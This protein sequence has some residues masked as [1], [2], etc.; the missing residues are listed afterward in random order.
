MVNVIAQAASIPAYDSANAAYAAGKYEKA[1]KLYESI[2]NDGQ[3][4][5]DLYFNLGNSYFKMNDL[6]SAILNYERAKEIDP[7][8]EDINI[9]LKLA[10][11]RTEDKIDA[12]PQLLF[13]QWENGIT[14]LMSEKEWGIFVIVS[15]SLA[16]LLFCIYVFG[17]SPGLR[18][19]GFFG[20]AGLILL[21]V[22]GFFMGQSQ[23]SAALESRSAIIMVPSVTVCSSPSDKGTKLFILHEGTKVVITEKNEEWTEIRIANGNVGWLKKS[24]LEEI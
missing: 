13:A 23:Y 4:S 17:T 12:A 10:N 15:V 3:E 9:N 20:G 2:L 18:Q 8:D 14:Q 7:D 1:V 6:G 19:T 24:S 16:M 21:A 11:Q 5:A 22:F